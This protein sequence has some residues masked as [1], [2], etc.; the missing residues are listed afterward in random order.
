MKK[1]SFYVITIITV[2]T[3]L[4]LTGCSVPGKTVQSGGT[5]SFALT[6][7]MTEKNMT[8]DNTA[9]LGKLKKLIDQ[10]PE[11]GTGGEFSFFYA[12]E[13][14]KSG[15]ALVT[16]FFAV[17][18]TGKPVKNVSFTLNVKAGD[19]VILK[20]MPITLSENTVGVLDNNTA[21]P[22]PLSL[23]KEQWDALSLI[24]ND[25]LSVIVTNY[26]DEAAE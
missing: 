14:W 9:S 6:K 12:G 10:N 25:N 22:I 24:T 17:N 13:E 8:A 5:V 4:S 23:T 3:L 26:S 18:R 1:I 19:T 16:A 11:I 2:V 21:V 20:D 7:E 15:N